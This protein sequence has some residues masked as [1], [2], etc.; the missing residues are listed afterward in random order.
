MS[1]HR[2]PDSQKKQVYG[3]AGFDVHGASDPEANHCRALT[4]AICLV[5]YQGRPCGLVLTTSSRSQGTRAGC[6]PRRSGKPCRPKTRP[7]P[8]PNRNRSPG[9]GRDHRQISSPKK[10]IRDNWA[11]ACPSKPSEL[12]IQAPTRRSVPRIRAPGVPSSISA[13]RTL[14]QIRGQGCPP[15]A[16]PTRA[17]ATNKRNMDIV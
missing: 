8:G 12:H 15:R 11:P 1:A 9:R 3:A 17:S 14:P 16:K 6:I 5:P 4:R 13:A 2:V 7:S 10:D